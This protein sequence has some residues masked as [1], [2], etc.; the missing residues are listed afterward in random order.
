[1]NSRACCRDQPPEAEEGPIIR[2]WRQRGFWL[3]LFVLLILGIDLLPGKDVRNDLLQP[4]I[5][6]AGGLQACTAPPA[7]AAFYN[8][9]LDI[10]LASTQELALLPGIGPVLAG[11]IVAAREANGPFASPEALLQV[12]G[13]GSQTL[14]ALKPHICTQ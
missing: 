14:A 11:R 6:P 12:A 13:I 9:P 5:V 1:M 10:N 2:N 4:Q 8:Q 7:Y 3:I